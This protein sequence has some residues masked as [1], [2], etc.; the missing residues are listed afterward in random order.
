MVDPVSAFELLVLDQLPEV[1]PVTVRRLVERFGS[2]EDALRA[3][4]RDFAAIAGWPAARARRDH[5]I[6]R[7]V[8]VAL[9]RAT[10]TDVEVV[11]WDDE[12]YPE[13]LRHLADPPPVLFLRGAMQLLG[14]RPSVTVV[15][16]R[17][18]TERA[19]IVAERLG[20]ALGRRG[21]C[22]VSGLA[23]GVD[24]AAHVGALRAAN[25]TIGVLGTGVDVSYPRAHATLHRQITNHGLLVSEFLP[26]TSA[27]PHHFPRR[28]RILA[29][30]GDAVVVVEA[31]RRSGSLITVD[32]A[33]DLGLD[34]WAVPGPIDASVCVGSNRLLADGARPLV[35][36]DDFADEVTRSRGG[37]G[38]GTGETPDAPPAPLRDEGRGGPH[39]PLREAGTGGFRAAE[40]AQ[41]SLPLGEAGSV[42]GGDLEQSILD[43]LG[44]AVVP[45]DEL[46]RRFGVPIS[47]VLVVLTTLE[48]F[49]EVERMPGMRF[50]RAA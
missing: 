4:S 46:A 28:N 49:G 6:R 39:G 35:S 37:E 26:G 36:V 3:R 43:A 47:E 33:L 34:V 32:H 19:R 42:T 11:T 31:G 41:R 45:A 7:L 13:R 14:H 23:L 8:E 40:R 5:G 25:R 48:L 24:G 10:T 44:E 30:L 12:T 27:A 15:G 38:G 2:A 29:A 16:A 1:G 20:G 50:R 22:V 18:A 17:R 9:N 21:V